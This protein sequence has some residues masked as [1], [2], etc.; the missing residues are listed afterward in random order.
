VKTVKKKLPS[1]EMDISATIVGK[2]NPLN[3]GF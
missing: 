1:K 3:Q 2:I